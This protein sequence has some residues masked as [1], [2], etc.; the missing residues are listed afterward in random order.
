MCWGIIKLLIPEVDFS[1]FLSGLNS[2]LA[3]S[4]LQYNPGF[5]LQ[6]GAL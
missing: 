5:R 6:V 1:L 2:S 4:A 3:D